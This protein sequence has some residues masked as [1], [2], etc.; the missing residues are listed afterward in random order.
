MFGLMMMG[1]M[2][3]VAPEPTGDTPDEQ[4]SRTVPEPEA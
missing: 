3:G 1:G 4:S 2:P